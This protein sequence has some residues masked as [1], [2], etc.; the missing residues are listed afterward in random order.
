VDPNGAHSAQRFV[1]SVDG[2]YSQQTGVGGWAAL[3]IER[4]I[5]RERRRSGFLPRG[6][7]PAWMEL[8]ALL[9]GLRSLPSGSHAVVRMDALTVLEVAKV[10]RRR[11]R[12]KTYALGRE[13][14]AWASFDREVTRL[15]R[16]DLHWVRGHSGDPGN[17]LA[18]ELAMQAR[19]V[20]EAAR[21]QRHPGVG[22]VLCG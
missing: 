15:A 12:V 7:G 14:R 17:A 22:A 5:G 8:F 20:G 4:P 9:E 2:S 11:T 13:Q 10:R 1:V 6:R 18:H 19:G 16:V 21:H 3:I